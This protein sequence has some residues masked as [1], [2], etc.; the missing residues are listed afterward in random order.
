MTPDQI[1]ARLHKL[2]MPEATQMVANTDKV[3]SVQ[4]STA[5]AM[6][7]LCAEICCSKQIYSI[8]WTD[9]ECGKADAKNDILSLVAELEGGA[10]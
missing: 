5:I 1:L 6:G 2:G 3:R 4:L 10:R 7:K 9:R 8:P